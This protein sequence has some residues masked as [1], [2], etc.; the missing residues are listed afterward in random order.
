MGEGECVGCRYDS[1]S[2][3]KT[4]T[5]KQVSVAAAHSRYVL[6][7]PI[8]QLDHI[9]KDLDTGKYPPSQIEGFLVQWFM[10]HLARLPEHETAF[11]MTV[12]KSQ[13]S[14]FPRIALVL[15]A[16]STRVVTRE[17]LYTG[18]TRAR[19]EVLLVSPESVLKEGISMR[20]SRRSGLVACL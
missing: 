12:H 11:A 2:V 10:V 19:S 3:K 6:S 17:L 16:V 14:E 9:V 18:V 1:D 7:T 8:C 5:K 13:G 15:P 4:A 20:T